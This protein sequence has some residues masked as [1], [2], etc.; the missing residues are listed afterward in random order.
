ML[1]V[2]PLN[3]GIICYVAIDNAYT[4]GIMQL[5]TPDPRQRENY[6]DHGEMELQP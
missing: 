4:Q 5:R 3:L 6:E 2:D 1:I